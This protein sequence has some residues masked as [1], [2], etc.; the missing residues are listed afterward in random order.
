MSEHDD[1]P[2]TLCG[3]EIEM[4]LS[5]GDPRDPARGDVELLGQY[6]SVEAYLKAVLGELMHPEITWILRHLDYGAV[7]QRFEADGGHYFCEAGMVYRTR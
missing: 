1:P 7:L 3:E 2:D 6:P 4:D 5:D